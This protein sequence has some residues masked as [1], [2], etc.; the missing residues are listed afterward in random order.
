MPTLLLAEHDNKSL[1]DATNKALTAAKAL[2]G[3]V[4][5]LVAGYGCKAVADAA[6]K[7]DGVEQ[8]VAG[9]RAGLRSH[10]GRADRGADRRARRALRNHHGGG[11]HDRKEHHAAGRGA[12]RRDADLRC[13][14]GRGAG[15][16]RA[17][18]LCRQRHPDRALARCQESDHR[19]HGGVP[20]DRRGRLGSRRSRLPPPPIRAFPASSARSCRSRSGRN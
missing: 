15:H 17:A 12:A 20:G 13:H 5:V 2:G 18:D 3:E 6:A 16:L 1:K 8:G 9:G 14:Q 10:A 4:H 19:A 11:D 7:L